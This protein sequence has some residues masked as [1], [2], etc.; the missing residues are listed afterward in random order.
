MHRS[1]STLLLSVVLLTG[2]AQAEDVIP[3]P[4]PAAPALLPAPD[5]AR[6]A[7]LERRLADSE[8]LRNELSSQLEGS[9]EE[10]ENAQLAYQRQENQ[11]LKLRLK[12]VQAQPAPGLFT[13]QQL[14]FLIGGG[15]ALLGTLFGALLR[16]KSRRRGEWLN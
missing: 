13:E 3:P 16:G 11:R 7:D 8:R 5:A 6:L 4:P 10:R 15:V 12:E 1:P 2:G 9:L 14:W